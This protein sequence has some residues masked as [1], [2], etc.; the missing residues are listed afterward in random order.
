MIVTKTAQATFDTLSDLFDALSQGFATP[1]AFQRLRIA[2]ENLSDDAMDRYVFDFD[3]EVDAAIHKMAAFVLDSRKINDIFQSL[4]TSVQLA[5]LCRYQLVSPHFHD[6]KESTPHVGVPVSIPDLF[7]W[8]YI[9][10]YR[11]LTKPI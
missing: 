9:D 6:A 5:L 10:L 1:Q 2:E 7:K 11:K 4:D 8:M 3:T